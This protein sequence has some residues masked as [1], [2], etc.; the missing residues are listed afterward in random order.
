MANKSP[1][2]LEKEIADLRAE[3]AT[4]EAARTEAE[5]NALAMAQ[6]SALMG[7]TAEEQPTG[8]TVT[9]RVCTNPT[10]K[11]SKQK[12]EMV[13]YPT[14]KYTILI[15]ESAGWSLRTNNMVEYFH[16][17]T[18]EFDLIELA[19]IKA[20]VARTWEHERSIKGSNEN[21][22]RRQ[23]QKTIGLRQH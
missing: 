8:K 12:Y 3:L 4:S 22:Y 21:A 14:Y 1:A 7:S 15:P 19:D 18:Y 5:Q 16:G 20:R 17:Q 9:R 2:E 13:E 23:T 6:A 11:P 10:E